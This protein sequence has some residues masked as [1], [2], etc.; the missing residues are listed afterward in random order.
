[1][2][3]VE[4]LEM[5]KANLQFA[6]WGQGTIHSRPH[7]GSLCLSEALTSALKDEKYI[8]NDGPLWEAHVAICDVIGADHR[9]PMSSIISWNDMR[10]RTQDDVL[11]VFDAAIETARGKTADA[12]Q[13]QD[14]A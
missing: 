11:K 1:M 7:K 2:S 12:G 5:A 6:G 8:R 14:H 10:G 13:Q 4:K 9:D 3:L